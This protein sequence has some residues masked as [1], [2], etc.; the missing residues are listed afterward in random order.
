MTSHPILTSEQLAEFDRRGVL[1]LP[2]LLSEGRVRRAREYVQGRLARLGLW[3]DGAWRLDARP[4]PRWPDTGVK[5]SRDIGNRHPDVEALIGEPALLAAVDVL[6]EGRP[7][8]RELFGRE[9]GMAGH[10]RLLKR[11]PAADARPGASPHVPS[12]T[13]VPRRTA[14]RGER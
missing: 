11:R 7:F 12:A 5:S 2:G 8:D 3:R 14:R 1:R 10:Q 13:A 9:D 6:L 4:R